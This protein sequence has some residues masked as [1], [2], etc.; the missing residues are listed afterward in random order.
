MRIQKIK[1]S[2]IN[3]TVF[4]IIL[5]T[6]LL[7]FPVISKAQAGL[8]IATILTPALRA[9]IAAILWLLF[10]LGYAILKLGIV[11]FEY[12]TIPIFNLPFTIPGTPPNG[13][14]VILVGWT[15]IRDITNMGFILGLV[16]IGLATA[17]RLSGFHTKQAFALLILI[18]LIINFTPVICGLIVDASNILMKFFLGGA[19]NWSK[20]EEALK[21]QQ[22]PFMDIFNFI[23]FNDLNLG[24]VFKALCLIAFG[25]I[26]GLILFMYAA[27][28]LVRNIAIWILV[29]FS[30]AAFFAY[31]FPQTRGLFNKWW[32]QLLQ[33]SFVGAI[34]AFFIYLSAYCLILTSQNPNVT[35]NPMPIGDPSLKNPVVQSPIYLVSLIFLI[36]GFILS[37]RTS[38]V[39]ANV[40][41]NLAKA[42][43]VS[44][45]LG[46]AA[47]GAA[48]S[49][50]LAGYL[51]KRYFEPQ[52]DWSESTRS[53]RF[54]RTAG[55]ILGLSEMPKD[56]PGLW[57][58]TSKA[59]RTAIAVPTAGAPFW[60]PTALKKA[61]VNQIKENKKLE[62]QIKSMGKEELKTLYESTMSPVEKSRIIT[63]ALS[64]DDVN[65][66]I[67][68]KSGIFTQNDLIRAIN[69]NK[70]YG[71]YSNV[72]KLIPALAGS[73]ADEE[74]TK[75]VIENLMKT[76]NEKVQAK[77]GLKPK[78]TVEK[79]LENIRIA[80]L[81]NPKNVN[82]I[83]EDMAEKLLADPNN[84]IY[85]KP[86]VLSTL[87]TKYGDKI[88]DVVN[89]AISQMD[90]K[91]IEEIAKDNPTILYY[92]ISNADPNL[93]GVKGLIYKGEGLTRNRLDELV[94]Q[95]KT[96]TAQ[97]QG[98]AQAPTN[99]KN[100]TRI[101]VEDALRKIEN[102]LEELRKK[103]IKTFADQKEYEDLLRQYESL[104]KL[105]QE[106]LGNKERN[107]KK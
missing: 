107:N 58:W 18:A 60:G 89:A 10:W 65:E 59:I 105:L 46:V 42:G 85:L 39:G 87:A 36:I 97:T 2:K 47:G 88:I 21:E 7:T 81:S 56:A 67:D 91:T 96:Q 69:Y 5:I 54:F 93:G 53:E 95:L 62:D 75:G 24:P 28:Y 44:V 102:R 82:F 78:E 106:L 30:P 49:Q 86:K 9:L 26:G 38:A 31:I 100:R 57:Q 80:L 25:L 17:L 35:I 40:V 76:S 4:G 72:K 51:G 98:Q 104:E 71:F 32:Q 29:I 83:T 70:N 64:R 74:T 22:V 55:S 19:T 101:E 34:A 20:L 12:S 6:I 61:Y 77:M 41:A 48:A 15:L 68:P 50:K 66:L 23:T 92:L 73:G 94:K 8:I 1:N 103:D 79:N 14:P 13:N 99:K 43:L 63:A 45:G 3:L 52:K 90:D 84:L 27:L 33:W 11:L 16:Y 37:T